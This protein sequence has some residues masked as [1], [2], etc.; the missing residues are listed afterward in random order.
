MLTLMYEYMWDVL[1]SPPQTLSRTPYPRI[2]VSPAV[3]EESVSRRRRLVYL[4][5]C[6]IIAAF[7]QLIIFI[8][9][10]YLI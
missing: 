4:P 3:F 6:F 2:P 9:V 7:C 1:G 8:A 10:K 5:I